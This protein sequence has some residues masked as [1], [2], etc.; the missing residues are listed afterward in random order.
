MDWLYKAI[1]INLVINNVW[2]MLMQVVYYNTFEDTS[3]VI[4][5]ILVFKSSAY[6]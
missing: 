5:N 2:L 6:V 1:T 3:K 4:N